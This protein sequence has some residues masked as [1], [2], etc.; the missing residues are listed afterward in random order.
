MTI[1]I[2]AVAASLALLT[3]QSALAWGSKGHMMINRLAATEFPAAMPAFVRTPDAVREIAALGP[4]EDLLKGSGVSWDADYDPGHYLD[5]GDD[6]KVDGVSL[7]ALPPTMKA[8]AIALE[9][10]H[11]T[12]WSAGYLPYSIEDGFEQLRDDFAYWRVEAYAAQHAKTAALRRGFAIERNLREVL[13]L[14]DLGVWGHFVA[15]ACQPLHVTV[16]FNGWGHYPNPR[17]FTQA[18]IHSLFES[19]FVNR[20]ETDALVEARVAP[21]RMLAPQHLL[22]QAEIGSIVETYLRGTGAAVVPLYEIASKGGFNRDDAAAVRFT[23]RQLARGVAELRDLSNLAWQDSLYVSTGY[24][25][26]G[27]SDVLAG[28][29]PLNAKLL[30]GMQ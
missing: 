19:S 8:Y 6:G 17:G 20:Y 27:V 25:S 11:A 12:P 21:N 28:K 23:A 7:S 13:T 1:R 30:A 18:P 26:H 22:S 10:E 29:V 5:L 2:L 9:P 16:H 4:E 14:R 15:D 3:P 24:P